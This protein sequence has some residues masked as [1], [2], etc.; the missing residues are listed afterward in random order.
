M[1]TNEI[2]IQVDLAE[3]TAAVWELANIARNLLTRL[4]E[5]DDQ[6]P[7]SVRQALRNKIEHYASVVNR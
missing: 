5:V 1:D 7:A 2:D 3:T 6:M 4:R